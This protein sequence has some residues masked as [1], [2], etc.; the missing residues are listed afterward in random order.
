MEGLIMNALEQ[1]YR[2]NVD[3]SRLRE[4]QRAF[5]L[6]A[7]GAT[8]LAGVSVKVADAET[9]AIMSLFAVANVAGALASRPRPR[10]VT[11]Q[12]CEPVEVGYRD[13]APAPSPRPVPKDNA[14]IYRVITL[15]ALILIVVWGFLNGSDRIVVY[16]ITAVLCAIVAAIKYVH[17]AWKLRHDAKLMVEWERRLEEMK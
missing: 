6:C 2:D 10:A 13:V 16:A 7:I 8:I 4:K 9:V 14:K 1:E 12:E 11:P 5:V 3:S 17:A 15:V